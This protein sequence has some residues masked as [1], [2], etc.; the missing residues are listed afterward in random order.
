MADYYQRWASDP[1]ARNLKFLLSIQV[2]DFNI[3]VIGHDEPQVRDVVVNS[4]IGLGEILEDHARFPMGRDN[5]VVAASTD[6]LAR[7]VSRHLADLGAKADAAPR[8]MGLRFALGPNGRKNRELQIA[9][10]GKFARKMGRLRIL[11]KCRKAAWSVFGRM[12][13]ALLAEPLCG[14]K[15]H[16]LKDAAVRRLSLGGATAGLGPRVV[17]GGRTLCS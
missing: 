17:A 5:T 4:A 3:T 14:C 10:L 8:R 16:S 2:G 9:R 12:H 1:D 6:D 7:K 15:V 11:S 13:L